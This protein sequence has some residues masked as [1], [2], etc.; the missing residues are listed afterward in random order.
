MR[1]S[2]LVGQ[3]EA[4]LTAGFTWYQ[5]LMTGSHLG[6]AGALVERVLLD[7]RVPESERVRLVV[8][9][10]SAMSAA[11]GVAHRIDDGGTGETMLADSLYVRCFVQDALAREVPHAVELLGHPGSTGSDGVGCLGAVIG[12]L[13]LQPPQQPRMTGPLAAYLIDGL[14]TVA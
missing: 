10:E 13:A 5:L 12:G 11:E 4:R 14:L 8:E 2:D 9:S 6:A 1:T 7:D 3:L